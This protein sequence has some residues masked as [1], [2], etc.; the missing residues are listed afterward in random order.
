MSVIK[1]DYLTFGEL[2]NRW[3]ITAHDMH[4]LV[5]K[6][7]LVPSI[8][9]DGYLAE[10]QLAI[11][12]DGE[13]DFMFPDRHK[14]IEKSGWLYLQFP[15][16]TGHSAYSFGYA[17]QVLRPIKD[18][19]LSEDKW[20]LLCGNFEYEGALAPERVNEKYVA[21]A[22]V[23]MLDSVADCEAKHP[24]L[25]ESSSREISHQQISGEHSD[26]VG[27]WPWGSYETELLGK[28][29]AAAKKF[30]TLYDPS[31]STTAPINQQVIDWL[32]EQGVSKRNAEVMATMLR[33]DGLA[34]GPR[35]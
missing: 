21:D 20:Y 31:D 5:A 17:T 19:F 32:V 10:C 35:R 2:C 1:K 33:A 26:V 23:F 6:S 12:S 15:K 29:S 28:L 11:V 18:G 7:D 4:Y 24:E 34:T 27:K 14:Y 30:W 25:I 3:K 8:A 13:P 16:F 22:G 9:W